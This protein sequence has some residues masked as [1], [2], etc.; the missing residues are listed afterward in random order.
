MAA[1]FITFPKG[2]NRS[3]GPRSPFGHVSAA[4]IRAVTFLLTIVPATPIAIA[5]QP[6]IEKEIHYVPG[7][8]RD[9]TLD[10]YLPATHNFPS[11]IFIHGGSL[12]EVGERRTSA[13]YQDVCPPL[14]AAG[15]ACATIDYRLAP[16]SKWPAMPE[17]AA[18]AVKWVKTNIGSRGGDPK[19]IVLFGHSSGCEL[20]SILGANPKYLAGVG[21]RPSDIA[22]IVAMGCVLAPLEGAM[23]RLSALSPEEARQRWEK[24]TERDTYRALDDWLDSDPSRF[25]GP[26]M[27]PLLVVV[28]EAERFMPAILEQGARTVRRLLE[29]QRP[30]NLVI[31]PGRH[32][33]SIANFGAPGDPTFAAVKSFIDNPLGVAPKD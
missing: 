21:L 19:R 14:A 10:L 17:D 25:I 11:V 12:Q 27:P 32:M 31:V 5:Q 6:A 9:Q 4:L 18:A 1:R 8:T 26:A 2:A 33:T 24:S 22:G 16:S 13:A 3:A 20:A 30:A 7:G 29:M 15:I 23:T 28:A